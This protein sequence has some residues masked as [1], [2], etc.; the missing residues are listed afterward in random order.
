LN[1]V[2]RRGHQLPASFWKHLSLAHLNHSETNP[3]KLYIKNITCKFGSFIHLEIW[4]VHICWLTKRANFC[5]SRFYC[6]MSIE[7]QF[8]NTASLLNQPHAFGF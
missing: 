3:T 2:A 7:R 6:Y 8:T 5:R 1:R 4:A